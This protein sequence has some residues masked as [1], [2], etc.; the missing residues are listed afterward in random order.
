MADSTNVPVNYDLTIS[1]ATTNNQGN[2]E[3]VLEG[4]N[5]G[6][7][8]YY[9]FE[10]GTSMAAPAVS[11]VLALFQDYFTNTLHETPSP[12]LL[13]AMLINGSRSIG[14]YNYALTNGNN[15]GRLGVA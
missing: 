4:L 9:R 12:A 11:G 6:L 7:A 15:F 5:N 3:Q 1:I 8:P 2:A 14:D 10:T 13:K